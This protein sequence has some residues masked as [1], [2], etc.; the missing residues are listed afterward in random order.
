[1][2]SSMGLTMGPQPAAAFMEIF[3]LLDEFG[4]KCLH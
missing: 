3:S 4:V 1:M 2:A